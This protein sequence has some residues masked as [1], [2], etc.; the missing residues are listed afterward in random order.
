MKKSILI[1]LSSF[2]LHTAVYAQNLNVDTL[3][4][5]AVLAIKHKDLQSLKLLLAK[6]Y[7][8]AGLDTRSSSAVLQQ[9]VENFSAFSDYTIE[10][11]V[12]TAGHIRVLV[13]LQYTNGKTGHPDLLFNR[14]GEIVELNIIRSPKL[15]VPTANS[16]PEQVNLSFQLINNCI[17]VAGSING[18]KGL[19]MIDS[20]AFGLVM[21]RELFANAIDTIN[22]GRQISGVNGQAA[23]A[24]GV[25]VNDLVLAGIHLHQ[26]SAIAMPM[27]KEIQQTGLPNLGLIGYSLLSKY[28]LT[29][30]YANRLLQLNKVDSLGNDKS[31]DTAALLGKVRFTMQ[32][33]LPIVT[34]Y[35]NENPYRFALDCGASH[36]LIYRDFNPN[37]K[38]IVS[39]PG[40]KTMSGIDGKVSAVTT[41]ELRSM[42]VEQMD[43]DN[44]ATAF[45]PNNLY[46]K[47]AEDAL[48][49][50]GLLG[51]PFFNTYKLKINYQRQELS[52]FK[53]K[54]SI[55]KKAG[56]YK[57]LKK[58]Q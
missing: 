56:H 39:N 3:A 18:L 54:Y 13:R 15:K 24:A 27:E 7:S 33:H 14:A 19:F 22:Y 47:S 1:C 50:D 25:K 34:A 28:T 42:Q 48:K 9:V 21:N 49:I 29:F 38:A 4:Q 37:W 43:F 20:G 23:E 32:R 6:E 44:M 10:N 36:N 31:L 35:I 26:L 52:V 16:L 30:D 57:S 58:G 17:Y 55:R 45:T 41:G 53:N 5:K 11:T 46:T 12:D 2:L 40:S 8:I 51:F